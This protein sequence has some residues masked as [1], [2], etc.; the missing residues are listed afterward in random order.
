M[1]KYN[2]E[3]ARQFDWSRDGRMTTALYYTIFVNGVAV[4]STY[5]DLYDDHYMESRGHV[6]VNGITH[7]PLYFLDKDLEDKFT[8]KL[9]KEVGIHKYLT[10]CLSG[11][12]G[13]NCETSYSLK[14]DDELIDNYRT[15]AQAFRKG[16]SVLW[17]KEILNMDCEDPRFMK[18]MTP[19]LNPKRILIKKIPSFDLGDVFGH[20]VE[21]SQIVI[22]K[23]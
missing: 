1:V 19:K 17:N 2:I 9:I 16:Y 18:M 4:I 14:V 23:R 10:D 11:M 8:G 15:K 12:D 22:K 6:D 20:Y 3:Y 5:E 13:E 7:Y 21:P